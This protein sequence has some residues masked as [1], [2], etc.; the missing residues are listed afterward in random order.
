MHAV[1]NAEHEMVNAAFQEPFKK[2]LAVPC[3]ITVLRKGRRW[4]LLLVSNQ[5][6]LLW[7]MLEWYEAIQLDALARLVDDKIL[8][9]ILPNY[10]KPL[11]RRH[12]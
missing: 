9:V 1:L 11:D 3:A 7:L 12:R 10:I 2:A 5:N 4:Q 8:D 6:H